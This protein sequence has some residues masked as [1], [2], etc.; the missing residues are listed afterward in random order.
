MSKFS[1][2]DLVNV[3]SELGLQL[4][5]PNEQL[6][7]IINNEKQY[8]AWFTP[9]SVLNAVQSIVKMLN[10]EDLTGWL[11]RYEIDK[12][13]Q[14]KRVGLILA[15]NIPLVG[16]HDVLCVLV[17]GNYALIKSSSQ[18]ARLIKYVLE[19][20]VTIDSR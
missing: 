16:F 6:L 8:N 7:H 12:N 18:D 20:L 17:T 15:G 2:T 3:F 10:R 9:E 1:K 11:S 13:S 19:M 4:T 5:H 14:A